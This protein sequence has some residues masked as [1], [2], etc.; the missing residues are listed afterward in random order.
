VGIGGDIVSRQVLDLDARYR[1]K[2]AA[3]QSSEPTAPSRNGTPSANGKAKPGAAKG[4]RWQTL[5]QFV[6]TVGPRLS[7]AE[8]WVWVTMSEGGGISRS[9]AEA[10]I[11][12]LCDLKLIWP[13]WLSHDKSKP[14]KYGV[15]PNPSACLS[16]ILEGKKPSRPSGRMKR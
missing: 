6:E 8:R 14:S 9:T 15:H 1:A 7:L 11:R 12:R 13:V 4:D 5:N 16:R 10:A 3:E 2:V